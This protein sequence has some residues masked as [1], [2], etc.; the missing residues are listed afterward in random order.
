MKQSPEFSRLFYAGV[1]LLGVF[2]SS[3]SQVLL[4]KAAQK[5]YDSRIKEYL[6]VP[7]IFAYTLFFGTT[8]LSVY[9]YKG[10]PLSWGPILESTG[11]LYVTVFGITIFHEKMNRTKILALLLIVSGIAVYAITV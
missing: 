8:L 1:L 2:I 7:V 11:Y 4:K 5:Q 3:I 6:N 9:S 10:I